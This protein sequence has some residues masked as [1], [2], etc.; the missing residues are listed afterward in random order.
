M[1]ERS[2]G[3]ITIV[4]KSVGTRAMGH[5]VTQEGSLK[6]A[7]SIWLTPVLKSEGLREQIKSWGRPSLF[8]IGSAD[9]HYR[10][11]YLED[12]RGTTGREILVIKEFLNNFELPKAFATGS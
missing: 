11:D 12:I 7:K 6:H 10:L 3:K 4:G 5:L 2:Y 9:P 8:I 1:K